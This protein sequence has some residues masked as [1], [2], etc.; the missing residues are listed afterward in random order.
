MG[1]PKAY[2]LKHRQ[3]FQS[4]YRRGRSERGC[5][6]LLRVLPA[7]EDRSLPSRVGIVVSKKVSKHAVTRNRI[8]R[9]LRSV[10]KHLSPRIATGW[11]VVVS[12][13]SGAVECEYE[14][15]LRELEEL[16]K[17]VEVLYGHSRNHF[18]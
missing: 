7:P 1:L 13:R 17:R 6:I 12:A 4:V 10:W 8:K 18:L 16:L 11:R 14:D 9:R 5:F 3:D 15:L 2:R